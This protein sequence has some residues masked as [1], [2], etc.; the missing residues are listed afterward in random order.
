[1]DGLNTS[2]SPADRQSTP[3]RTYCAPCASQKPQTPPRKR[4][5]E[6]EEASR[7][8]PS[9]APFD[10]AD[11]HFWQNNKGG[12]RKFDV[13]RIIYI[14]HGLQVNRDFI[15]KQH[16]RMNLLQPIISIV[17]H[18]KSSV[19][20]TT[21]CFSS[22]NRSFFGEFRPPGGVVRRSGR[23]IRNWWACRRRRRPAVPVR[24]GRRC[25]RPGRR[26]GRWRGGWPAPRCG[27]RCG[28]P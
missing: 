9:Y 2:I 7:R 5:P 16:R 15:E 6:P 25:C 1:M 10:A 12:R 22:N 20:G 17:R 8:S 24:R 21:G 26:S 4:G 13:Q 27:R 23:G 11:R 3:P 14:M 18:K 19:K 28:V